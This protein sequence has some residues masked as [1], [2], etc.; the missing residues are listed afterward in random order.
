MDAKR[1]SNASIIKFDVKSCQ[2]RSSVY[3]HENVIQRLGYVQT[4]DGGRTDN[5]DKARKGNFLSHL[6]LISSV[7]VLRVLMIR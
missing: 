7:P 1:K 2:H 3:E 5:E 4:V 6:F